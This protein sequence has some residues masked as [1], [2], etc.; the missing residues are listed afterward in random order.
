MA[1]LYEYQGKALLQQAHI[2]VPRGGPAATPER[3]REIATELGGPVVI[4]AQ[5]WVTGR[6]GLGAIRFADSPEQAEM[7]ARAILGMRLKH[8]TVDT[9]MVEEKLDIRREFYGGV[10]IDDARQMPVVIFSSRGG[11][12]VEE[13][14]HDYPEAVAMQPVDVRFGLRDFEARNLV[15]RAGLHGEL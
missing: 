1:R 11:S 3:A 8:F 12:G 14:S 15:R 10:I 9:V 6:A 2:L 13:I 7:E 4:K 5:A